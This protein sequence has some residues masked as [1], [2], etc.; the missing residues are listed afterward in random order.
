[1][2]LRR[3]CLRGLARPSPAIGVPTWLRS[4]YPASLV[5]LLAAA[6]LLGGCG[7]LDTVP[8]L[9]VVSVGGTN[10]ASVTRDGARIVFYGDPVG[11]WQEVERIF[12][13]HHR[14]DV[15]W[16]GLQ[17]VGDGIPVV[18]PAAELPLIEN[19]EAFWSEFRGTRFHDYAQ[20][21]TKILARNVP[22]QF[23]P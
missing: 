8:G 12:W 20:Q 16:A 5:G 14:R 2:T 10:G 9:E 21:S 7:L 15:A 17:L 3:S 1:M 23:R 11:D 6:L 19:A 22:V 18:A 4:P 13:T